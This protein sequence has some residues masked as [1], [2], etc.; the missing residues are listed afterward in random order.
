M[1]C[2]RRFERKPAAHPSQPH[3]SQPHPSQ[4][5][6]TPESVTSP[7]LEAL[8]RHGTSCR[9]GGTGQLQAWRQG[10]AAGVEARAS[11]RRGGTGSGR[12]AARLR[13]RRHGGHAPA[14]FRAAGMQYHRRSRR[15]ARFTIGSL[16]SVAPQR[17]SLGHRPRNLPSFATAT[18]R[19]R[20]GVR[21][22]S[23][24]VR[25]CMRW[26]KCADSR[27]ISPTAAV[28]AA[29]VSTTSGNC[30]PTA[31]PPPPP[32]S[33]QPAPAP[34]Q[35]RSAAHPR[36]LS[37]FWLASH[38]PARLRGAAGSAAQSHSLITPL[39]RHAGGPPCGQGA[40]ARWSPRR[41]LSQA[42]T[43]RRKREARG[44]EGGREARG[45]EGGVGGR[46]GNQTAEGNWGPGHGGPRDQT[47]Q[48]R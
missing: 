18:G 28:G 6:S 16:Q 11:C 40:P 47:A 8:L 46:A 26:P 41:D 1:R 17:R 32:P 37:L 45:G 29:S 2:C 20:G 44:G 14:R 43:R 7:T 19:V 33:S 3:P 10:P 27:R 30:P 31:P 48:S 13:H 39:P 23:P 12:H 15:S 35:C 34:R 9:R 24:G 4:A 38:P 5:T 42:R 22:L 36:P 25:S 21:V